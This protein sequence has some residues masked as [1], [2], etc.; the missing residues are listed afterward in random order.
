MHVLL[1]SEYNVTVCF[2]HCF[3]HFAPLSLSSPCVFFPSHPSWTYE[4]TVWMVNVAFFSA[5]FC[6]PTPVCN[7][8]TFAGTTLVPVVGLHCVMLSLEITHCRD[9]F[10]LV[11]AY[12]ITSCAAS[13]NSWRGTE[14]TQHSVPSYPRLNP[15]IHDWMTLKLLSLHRALSGQQH[16]LPCCVH[17]SYYRP[18]SSAVMS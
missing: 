9:C 7:W 17:R 13:T 10:S 3:L 16:I 6:S 14:Q 15:M 12:L 11:I 2:A 4:T 8:L 18:S 5:V 1:D